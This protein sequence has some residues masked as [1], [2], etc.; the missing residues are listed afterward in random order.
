MNQSPAFYME[1]LANLL[2]ET[3][4]KNISSLSMSFYFQ[5]DYTF[6]NPADFPALQSMFDALRSKGVVAVGSAGNKQDTRKNFPNCM[7][8]V[9]IVGACR[10]M[11]DGGVRLAQYSGHGE[12]VD[13]YALSNIRVATRASSAKSGIDD[14]SERQQ[15]TSYSTPL[16]AGAAAILRQQAGDRIPHDRLA[17]V[18][19]WA[20]YH[21]ANESDWHRVDGVNLRPVLDVKLACDNMQQLLEGKFDVN[22]LPGSDEHGEVTSFKDFLP[23]WQAWR[24]KNPPSSRDSAHSA[25]GHASDGQASGGYGAGSALAIFGAALSAAGL[26]GYLALSHRGRRKERQAAERGQ[27]LQSLTNQTGKA[28]TSS[29][30]ALPVGEEETLV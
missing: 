29:S 8:G 22:N 26:G 16:V 9:M 11:P 18:T 25:S 17:D 28:G 6:T 13:I 21:R 7:D 15:G 19:T 27:E 5:K 23:R 10:H 24:Q 14:V 20:L 1:V 2:Q 12:M 3:K 30:A 4:H